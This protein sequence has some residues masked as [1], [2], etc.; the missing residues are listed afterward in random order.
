MLRG[1]MLPLG[2]WQYWAMFAPDPIRDT[3]FLEAEVIDING[4]RYRFEFPRMAS[5]TWW[6]GIGHFRFAKYNANIS[7]EDF[8]TARTFAARHVLRNLKLPSEAYP[9][10]VHLIYQIHV[11]PP[12]PAENPDPS[13]SAEAT[14][15]PTTRSA[16]VGTIRIESPRELN[17]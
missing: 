2:L 16:V 3:I 6:Q 15:T 17:L 8:T 5:Y 11:T 14:A 13:Q 10:S 7:N 1:Y 9:V 4:M 12:L